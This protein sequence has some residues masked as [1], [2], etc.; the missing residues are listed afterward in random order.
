MTLLPL[1]YLPSIAYFHQLQRADTIVLEAHEHY[2]KRSGRNRCRIVGANGIQ[3]LSLPLAKGKNQQQPI[4]DVR[5][6]YYENWRHQHWQS[7]RSAYGNS[8][9]Y[10]YY[11][12]E[13]AT[14]YERRYIFL[15]DLN[16][17]LLT[18]VL[19]CLQW[20][21]SVQLTE[22][23][24]VAVA[25]RDLRAGVRPNDETDLPF[26]P[27]GQVFQERHGFVDNLS[28][29]DLLFCQGPQADLYL[30]QL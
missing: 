17:E 14:F 28:I 7:I 4:R 22:R 10:P 27:Y 20:D 11:A 26:P 3:R 19:G 5:L 13:L 21:R 15:W 12:D 6:A 9:F 8:P 24:E 18:W 16:Y 30:S 2:Q 23:Y 29:L 1:H 25:G